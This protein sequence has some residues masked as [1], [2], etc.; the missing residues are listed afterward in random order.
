MIKSSRWRGVGALAVVAV[1]GIAFAAPVASATPTPGSDGAGDGYYPQDG[2]GGY[3]VANYELAI[4]YDPASHQL[5]G[6]QMVTARAT[7]DLSSFN[8]DLTGLTVTSVKVNGSAATFE[9]AG[10]HELVITPDQPLNQGTEFVAEIAYNGNPGPIDDPRLGLNGWQYSDSG[11]AF[12]SGE[13]HSATTWYPV[14]DTPRDKATFHLAVTVPDEWGVIA[15]GRKQATQKSA[16]GT[17]HLWAEET[18]VAP[19]L[20]TVAIDKWQFH[21]ANLADGTP[22]VSAFA[23]GTSDATKAADAR[24]PEVLDFL[25]SKFG[26]YPVDA[27]GGIYLTEPIGFSLETLSRPI[28]SGQ[29]GDLETIVH[30]NAHQWYGD[31]VAV[32]NWKDVCLNECFASYATWM[33]AKY[34]DNQN[35]DDYYRS[36]VETVDDEFWAGKLY[37]MG[38]GNEFTSVY[39]K[40]PMALH[41][42]R[43]QIGEQAF[44]KL[45]RT[46]PSL[47]QDGNATLPQ[48]QRYAQ[49]VSGQDLSEF[50]AA[51]FYGNSK[52]A[53]QYLYPGEL[54][55]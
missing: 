11:G 18:P 53:E 50:F 36:M 26:E 16:N 31:S 44:N 8:L 51:W 37:D 54:S 25:S 22:V 23:P 10:Q 14:N 29:A 28:Y 9:R 12:V 43:H 4:D 17:T 3:D 13:P 46:W 39:S 47:H 27:A 49:V 42:L 30:E 2:N 7:Q 35:L 40:G 55:V 20:T 34:N 6:L 32:Q 48:F 52:P 45:L 24:L 15:N 38:P 33:W 41:A 5:D 21:E 1:A 19:Y